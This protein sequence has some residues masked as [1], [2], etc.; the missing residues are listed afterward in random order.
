MKNP[1]L[2]TAAALLGGAV[3]LAWAAD[4]AP[5]QPAKLPSGFSVAHMDQ[6]VDPKVDFA[7]FAAGGWYKNFQMPADKSRFGAF[8]TLEQNNWTNVKAILEEV[9]AQTHPQGTLEQKVGDFFASAMN[10]AAIDAAGLAPLQPML[11]QID[12]IKDL[13]TLAQVVGELRRT[14]GGGLFGQFVFADQKKSDINALYISQGGTSLPSKDY[15]F[16]EGFAKVREQFKEHIAKMFVLAGSSDEQAKAAAETILALETA[17]AENAKTPVE[18]RDRIA[19]YNRVTLPELERLFGAFPVMTVLR[20]ANLKMDA[21]DYAIVG[22]PKFIE[23]LAKQLAARPISDWKTY[24][25]YRALVSAA[26]YLAAP[27]EQEQFRFYSTVLRGTPQMEPRW[28]RAARV[29]DGSIGEALGQLYVAKHF[30]PEAKARMD[31]MIKNIKAV[32]RDRLATLEWMSPPTREK[33]LAKFARFEARIGYPEK[34]RDYSSVNVTR[35]SYFTNVRSATGFEVAR[36]NAKLGQPVDKSEWGMTPPTVNAYFSPTANQIVFPA[37]ILQP[38]FFDFT[39]DDAVNYGM[40][41]GVIGHEITH[42]FDDQGRRYDADGNLTDWWTAEDDAQ[43]RARAQKLIDQYSSYEALPGLKVNGALSLG[44]NVADLGGTS[45][46][47][48]AFQRSLK[49]K[50]TPPKIDG[51]TAE[52]RFFISW[53]QGWRTSYRDDAMRRQVMVGPHAPGNFRAIGPLVNFQPF[54]D[55]FGIKEGDPMWKKPEDRTKIW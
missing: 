10:T 7:K 13:A 23:G 43:F 19:N 28:Q 52:Q 42:G 24:L 30:P 49:G 20:G 38:P 35:N 27:F 51:F 45:I 34:W 21:V 18:L 55:A 53:A 15:Y 48:E 26:P 3:S 1:R 36:N 9:S 14:G 33:A 46:A 31:E 54:F 25:R 16:S 12:G 39:K 47:F 32:M 37:G 22:Q 44:E 8:D 41:G 2:L 29:V 5:A 11:D 50:P 17:L 6:S 40:I 4:P